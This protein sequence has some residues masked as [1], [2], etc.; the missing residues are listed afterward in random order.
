MSLSGQVRPVTATR[1][2]NELATADLAT[3]T[4]AIERSAETDGLEDDAPVEP[5]F[6]DILADGEAALSEVGEILSRATEAMNEIGTLSQEAGAEIAQSDAQGL[7][8]AGRLQIARR[9]ATNLQSPADSLD[10]AAVD[11]LDRVGPMDVMIKYMITPWEE[12]PE[13]LEE[14]REFGHSFLFLLDSAEESEGGV[15]GMLQGARALKKSRA[16]LRP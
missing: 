6:M 3:V 11:F 9:L 2:W 8:F 16:T 13:D 7:G 1:L 10:S 5:G 4:A 12:V 14:S 15:R